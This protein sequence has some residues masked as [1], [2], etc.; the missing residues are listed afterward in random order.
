MPVTDIQT[1]PDSLTVTITA[2]YPVPARRLWDAYADPRRIER[3]WG[4]PTW[5]ATFVR[6]DMFTGGRS[7]Y[8]MTGPDGDRQF[9]LWNF[10]ALDEGRSFEVVDGFCGPD[11]TPTQ[12]M[13]TMRML[14]IFEDTRHGSRLTCRTWFNDVGELEQLLGMGM[15][16][17]TKEAMSQID[18]A[19]SDE[20]SFA[21]GRPTES[22]T[23]DETRIRITRVL[24]ADL[25]D[26]WRGHHDPALVARWMTGPEGWSMPECTAATEVGD[27]YR[28]VWREDSSGESFASI[29]RVLESMPPRREVTT[30]RFGSDDVPSQT[31]GTRNELTLT[32]MADGTLVSL[33][34]T[35]ADVQARDTALASGIV[36]GME[37][38]YSRLEQLL[39][40]Q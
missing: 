24:D 31:P 22:R 13:P 35:H 16:E 19:L 9:G 25:D 34:I 40:L 14:F 17:G 30:E 27:E 20:D 5:P 3:F 23:L 2:D 38:G 39:A 32:P 10:R 1:D 8:F 18:A 33:V 11:G 37:Y 26:L 29:G 28:Y 15:L 36:D 6:H 7:I 12:G 21:P 4:P